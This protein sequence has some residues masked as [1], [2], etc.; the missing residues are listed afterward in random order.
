MGFMDIIKGVAGAIPVAGPAISAGLGLLQGREANKGN[1]ASQEAYNKY[2]RDLQ[3]RGGR[4]QSMFDAAGFDPFAARTTTSGGTSSGTSDTLQR[5]NQLQQQ[6]VANSPQTQA[7]I[8]SIVGQNQANLD[9]PSVLPEGTLSRMVAAINQTGG[10]AERAAMEKAGM[11]GAGA[12][13]TYGALSG[14]SQARAAQ[15]A[16]L[17]ANWVPGGPQ[18]QAMRA[19]FRNE[20]LGTAQSQAGSDTRTTGTTRTT[21]STTGQTSGSSTGP[22]SMSDIGNYFNMIDPAPVGPEL[23]MTTGQNPWLNAGQDLTQGLSQWF[24]NK[25]KAAR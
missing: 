6:R 4:A 11:R 1:L 18:E 20:A 14:P 23:P 9:R 13:Q 17:V 8:D 19:Q 15:I 5:I 10:G 22:A 3:A 7:L 24:A 12:G 16:D 2:I 21:G 25:N